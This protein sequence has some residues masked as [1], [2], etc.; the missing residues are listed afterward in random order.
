MDMWEAY[1]NS[2][3]CTPARERRRRWFSTSFILRSIWAKAV[4]DVRRG[5]TENLESDRDNRLTGTRYQWLKNPKRLKPTERRQF[6]ELR[7]VI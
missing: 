7:G 3:S 6:A 1:L 2:I 4:D 5:R